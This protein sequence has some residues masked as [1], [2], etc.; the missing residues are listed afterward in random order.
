MLDEGVDALTPFLAQFRRSDIEATFS[1]AAH[2]VPGLVTMTLA[3]TLF[4]THWVPIP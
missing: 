1:K 3:Q 2:S 4:F